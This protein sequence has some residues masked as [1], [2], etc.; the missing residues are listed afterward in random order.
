MIRVIAGRHNHSLKLAR[1][2]QKKKYR[3]ERGLLVAE[4]MDLLQAALEAEAHIV[5]VL[6]RED[7]VGLLPSS[8]RQAA[9]N[10]GVDETARRVDV[11]I[12][13]RELLE[14]ASSLGGG[15]DVVFICAQPQW[16]LSQIPLGRGVTF[17]LDGVG[18]PG[19]VGTVIRSAVAFGIDAV[20]CSPGTADPYGPKA[21]RA[22]MGAQFCLPVVTEVSPADLQAKLG[23]LAEKG[24]PV[25]RVLVADPRGNK[26]PRTLE[27]AGGVVVVLGDERT[28]PGS[29]WVGAERV[30][31]PQRRFDSLNVAM[32]GT[33]LAY[34]LF[35]QGFTGASESDISGGKTVDSSLGWRSWREEA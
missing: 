13:T 18:D 29:E 22:G 14:E 7:L 10:A 21:L 3:R 6:V 20:C 16:S 23:G 27:P 35:R 30:I 12:C 17:F 28:G 9:E 34:E 33:V 24:L 11:G 1:K 4:G 15:A 32:A 19:N 31:I 5:E 2:L 8:L 25:P 26:D